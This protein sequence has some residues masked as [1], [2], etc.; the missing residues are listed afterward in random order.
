[1]E[2]NFIKIV[3]SIY[4]FPWGEVWNIPLYQEQEHRIPAS[5]AANQQKYHLEFRVEKLGKN[6]KAWKLTRKKEVYV[7][8][9][10]A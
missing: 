10:I 7:Y 3:V 5:I 4:G 8:L 9:Q 1:M 6:E 2:R